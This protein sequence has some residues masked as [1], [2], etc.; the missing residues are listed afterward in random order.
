MA[1]YDIEKLVVYPV[2][3]MSGNIVD[4]VYLEK[5]GFRGDRRL[6]L[7][8]PD[9]R[10]I[11]Q[12]EIPELALFKVKS[13]DHRLTFE[14]DQDRYHLDLNSQEDKLTAVKLWSTNFAAQELDEKASEWISDKLSHKCRIVSLTSGSPR[15]KYFPKPPFQS[16]VS[17]ADGYPLLLIG[18]A[19]IDNLNAKLDSPISYNRFRPSILIQTHDPHIE[20]NWTELNIGESVIKIIKPCARCMVTTIDQNTAKRGSE[21]LKTLSTY[22]L[23]GNKINFGVNAIVIKPGRIRLTDKVVSLD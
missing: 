18:T 16:K 8:D 11:S 13:E 23:D 3:G 6:M 12:R 9:G 5:E 14:L 1:T 2:K 19:S 20:D 15:I 4:E 7:V 21:P 10:F 17:F 22:R